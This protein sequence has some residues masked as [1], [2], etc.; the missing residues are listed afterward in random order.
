MRKY[1]WSQVGGKVHIMV[2]LIKVGATMA[3]FGSDG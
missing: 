3:N 1:W 2:S